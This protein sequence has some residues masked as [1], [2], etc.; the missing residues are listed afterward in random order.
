MT[1]VSSFLCLLISGAVRGYQCL[2]SPFLPHQCR[3]Y[4]TCSDYALSAL[5]HH[6]LFTGLWRSFKRILSCHPFHHGGI[7]YNWR[8][9]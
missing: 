8:S 9:L 3:F 2:I 1:Y 7:D 5:R 6:G 4:P